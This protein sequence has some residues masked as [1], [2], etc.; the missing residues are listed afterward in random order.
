MKILWFF[1]DADMASNVTFS[2]CRSGSFEIA[3]AEGVARGTKI[4]VHLKDNDKRFA[5]KSVVEG[6]AIFVLF[7]RLLF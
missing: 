6:I 2:V 5:L 1:V 3:E 4:T 7:N